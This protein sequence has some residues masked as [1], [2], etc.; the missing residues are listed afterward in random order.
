M[1]YR[2]R[3]RAAL[4]AAYNNTAAVG[5]TKRAAYVADWTRRSDA[6]RAT[7][8]ARLDLRY[9]DGARHRLDVFPCGTPVAPTL[10]YIHGGYWQMNDKDPDALLGE[11]LRV[12]GFNL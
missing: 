8:G 3:A 9:G 7:P 6:I 5:Q 2:G 11:G 10:V 12:V 4:D 1:L